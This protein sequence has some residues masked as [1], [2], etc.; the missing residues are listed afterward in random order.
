MRTIETCYALLKASWLRRESDEITSSSQKDEGYFHSVAIGL[1][2]PS[3]EL[4]KG[5]SQRFCIAPDERHER[6]RSLEGLDVLE[7]I[8]YR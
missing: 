1:L 2:A 6:K 3:L 4:F 8:R 5:S 7:P